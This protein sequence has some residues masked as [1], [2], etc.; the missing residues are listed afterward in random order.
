MRARPTSKH[1]ATMTEPMI[2]L[3]QELGTVPPHPKETWKRPDAGWRK[4]NIDASFVVAV[5]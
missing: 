1:I 2:C 5:G 3:G 4:V